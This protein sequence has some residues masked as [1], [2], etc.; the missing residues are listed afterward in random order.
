MNTRNIQS[1]ALRA[2]NNSNISSKTQACFRRRASYFHSVSHGN[3]AKRRP[4]SNDKHHSYALQGG[5]VEGV[6]VFHRHGD[7]TPSRPLCG[8]DMIEEEAAFWRTKLPSLDSSDRLNDKFSIDVHESHNEEFLDAKR[9]PYG[10]LTMIGMQQMLKVGEKYH[11]RH[12]ARNRVAGSFAGRHENTAF[13]EQWDVRVFST[14]YLRTVMSAQCFLD[15]LLGNI[16][17]GVDSGVSVKVRPRSNDT[18][19]A[20]DRDPE[21]MLGLVTDVVESDYFQAQDAIA[22]PLAAKLAHYLPGLLKKGHRAH[23]G[24]SGINWIHATDHFVCRAAHGTKFTSLDAHDGVAEAEMQ[25]LA[26]PSLAHLSWRFRQWYTSPP[27]LA[28]IGAPPLREIELQ[29]KATP[30]VPAYERRPF[31]IYSCH[32]VTILALLYAIGANIVLDEASHFWPA[33]A[34]T[35][36]FELVKVDNR[37][38]SDSYIVRILL[39]GEPITVNSQR[40]GGMLTMAEFSSIVDKVESGATRKKRDGDI[41]GEKC[42]ESRELWTG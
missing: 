41:Q 39:N 12:C 32:D 38:L 11:L 21:F 17:E 19:N 36:A 31:T 23:G 30:S 6:W 9:E 14:N 5:S 18:L 34:T 24:P 42:E 15:G 13:L 1:L 29:L 22:A 2:G 35:L 27:L 25:E 20:F 10:Y 16:E 37:D 4:F 8:E 26:L 28:A 40:I 3:G 33:Y 7:R